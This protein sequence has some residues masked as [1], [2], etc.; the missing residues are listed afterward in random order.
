MNPLTLLQ[1][2]AARIYSAEL[3]AAAWF[4]TC[5]VARLF[6][7]AWV[8]QGVRPWL[9]TGIAVAVLALGHPGRTATAAIII[10][11]GAATVFSRIAAK[12]HY[13]LNEEDR[14]CPYCPK[15]EEPGNGGLWLDWDNNQPP[16][17]P[18][19][20]ADYD[21]EQIRAMAGDLDAAYAELC[22]EAAR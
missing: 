10:V 7:L 13:V 14:P 11:C 6:P 21:D 16:S 22:G 8:H 15:G 20:M 17:A 3:S 4:D 9:P 1:Y 12:S 2:A 5:R 18:L 19:P